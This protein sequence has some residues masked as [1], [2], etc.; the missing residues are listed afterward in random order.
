[1]TSSP[2]TG[3]GAL[4]RYEVRPSPLKQWNAEAPDEF[5]DKGAK[6]LGFGDMLDAINP[7]QQ[8][9]VVGSIYRAVTGATIEPAAR[10]AGGLIF[11]GLIGGIGAVVN[12][13]T[14]SLSGKDLGGHLVAMVAPGDLPAPPAA[15]NLPA[16]GGDMSPATEGGFLLASAG[17]PSPQGGFLERQGLL[18]TWIANGAPRETEPA[19]PSPPEIRSARAAPGQIPPTHISPAQVAAA[20]LPAVAV[21]PPAPVIAAEAPPAARVAEPPSAPVSGPA[22]ETRAMSLDAY[23]ARAVVAPTFTARAP[24]VNDTLGLVRKAEST[25]ALEALRG[26]SGTALLPAAL[27]AQQAFDNAGESGASYFSASMALGLERYRQMQQQRAEA[28]KSGI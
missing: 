17:R 6:P 9:P 5:V 25:R 26:K 19:I 27:Q 21:P 20:E 8:L 23:R 18:T 13:V 16:G 11:G 10:V 28:A 15:P 3:T 7:L 1:M 24:A 4:P 14:E 22:G 2:D 12:A